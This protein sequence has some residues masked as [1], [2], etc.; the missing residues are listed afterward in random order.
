MKVRSISKQ[1]D[2]DAVVLTPDEFREHS[3]YDPMCYSSGF[4]IL[5]NFGGGERDWGTWPN[6]NACDLVIIEADSTERRRLV[7]AGLQMIN[8]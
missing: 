7:E 6:H 5:V 3:S 8:L 1:L 4:M 2:F